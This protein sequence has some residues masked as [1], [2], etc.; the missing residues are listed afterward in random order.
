[1][2][3]SEQRCRDSLVLVHETRMQHVEDAAE[4]LVG[5]NGMEEALALT[6]NGAVATADYHSAARLRD[7]REDR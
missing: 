2:E 7:L 5:D 1:M 6:V 3:R 4:S